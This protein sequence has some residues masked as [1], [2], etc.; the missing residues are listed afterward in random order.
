MK[1]FIL[2]ILF[3]FLLATALV[4]ASSDLSATLDTSSQSGNPGDTVSFILTL[5]NVGSTISTV[6]ISSSTLVSGSNTISAPSISD[7]SDLTSTDQTVTFSVALPA[8]A[9]GTYTGTITAQ[10]TT[11]SANVASIPYS[12]VVNSKNA[13][14]V[15]TS[16]ISIATQGDKETGT[17]TVTN[18]GS[19]TL[20]S[21]TLN[22]TSSDGDSGKILD[23]NN[24]ELT[25]S[26]S[27]ASSSLAPG[28]SMTMT[29]SVTPKS[30]FNTGSYSG[31][32]SVAATG[33]AVVSSSLGLDVSMNPDICSDGKQGNN[34]DV[35]IRKPSSG[36]DFNPGES[37]PVEVRVK[38]TG[39]DNY[40][41][42]IE[43]IL[44]NTDT[45]DKEEVVKDSGS[46]D[47][48][49]TETFTE[50]L[51]IPTDIDVNDHYKLYVQVHE[52]GN[53]DD[54]CEYDSIN[55]DMKRATEGLQISD[56]SVSPSTGLACLDSY[57]VSF[58]ATSTG[59]N[60]LKGL[61]AEL[62]DSD[63]AVKEKSESFD[64][65]D[66]NDKD[67]DKRLS[68]DLTLPKD[69]EAGKTYYL[70]A[71]LYNKNGVSMDSVLVPVTVDSCDAAALL[72]KLS[73]S[74]S[75]TYDATNSKLTL[76][77]LVKNSADADTTITITPEDVSWGTLTS[78]EYLADL[79]AGSEEHAYLYYTLDTSNTGSHDLKITVTDDNGNEVSKVVTVDFGE[80]PGSSW[81]ELV[82]WVK[83]K[84]NSGFWVLAD[85]ILVIL[86]LVFVRMLFRKK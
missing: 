70:E 39:N 43:V 42:A 5:H 72:G 61:Y 59:K 2:S 41:V 82:A 71:A 15:S 37:I 23:D 31:T 3:V 17:F 64:L 11:T 78:S 65:G 77:L 12:V 9:A 86:A 14:S 83:A 45:G 25:V 1:R 33:T 28:A 68:F 69:A 58:T 55:L 48:D 79:S 38:N 20:S 51:V 24:D 32:I 76:S 74:S 53:E 84:A 73:F 22:F 19:T 7:V 6:D 16:S 26:S 49:N 27:A 34:F 35:S 54:N 29:T 56:V 57:R 10:D 80:A 52:D 60:T 67:N 36:D 85:I 66:Y 50:D 62:T 47:E 8:I 46:V 81:S 75:Q 21:W 44:L 13:F 4:S 18:T 40:D 63:I 30:G